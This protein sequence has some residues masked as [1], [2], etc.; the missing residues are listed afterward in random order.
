MLFLFF[1]IGYGNG[2]GGDVGGGDGTGGDGPGGVLYVG[3]V[4]AYLDLCS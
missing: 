4:G 2:Y 1:T 3:N